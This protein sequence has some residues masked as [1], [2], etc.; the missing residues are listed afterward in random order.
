MFRCLVCSNFDL[1]SC[2]EDKYHQFH[3]FLEVASAEHWPLKIEVLFDEKAKRY[4]KNE[5]KE[6]E[7]TIKQEK[8]RKYR[9]GKNQS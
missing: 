2:C 3:P 6:E 8:E 9:K 7:I 5:L 4:M 1:C